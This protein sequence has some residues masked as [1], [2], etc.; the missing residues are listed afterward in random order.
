MSTDLLPPDAMDQFQ[1]RIHA[2]ALEVDELVVDNDDVA[3]L[4]NR[5]LHEVK[6]L[7]ASIIEFIEPFRLATKRAYDETL[8]RK[9][10]LVVPLEASEAKLKGSLATW[11]E[12]QERLR[13][14]AES[15]ALAT[16][17]EAAQ[18]DHDTKIEEAIDRGDETTAE[19]LMNVPPAIESQH[20]PPVV[21]PPPKLEGTSYRKRWVAECSDIKA[22]CRAIAEGR[23]SPD[24]V[25]LNQTEANRMAGALKEQLTR[26]NAGLI[27]RERTDVAVR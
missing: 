17:K 27:A 21:K 10:Q 1:G 12:G 8:E 14:A 15:A 19:H 3:G 6:R 9:K 18:R 4:A 13:L 23:V 25:K 5:T 24:L 11:H 7:K 22:L 26:L 20:L 2:I 16:A